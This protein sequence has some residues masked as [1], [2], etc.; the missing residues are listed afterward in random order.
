MQVIVYFVRNNIYKALYTRY[1]LTHY[2]RKSSLYTQGTPL[3]NFELSV[4]IRLIWK[5]A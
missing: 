5:T 2:Y 3:V 4:E 1:L